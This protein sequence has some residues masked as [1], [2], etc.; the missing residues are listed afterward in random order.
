MSSIGTRPAATTGS[1]RDQI[2]HAA[3]RLFAQRGVDGVTVRE[4]VSASGQRNHGSLTYYF[5]TKDA[6]VRELV[7]DGAAVIDRRRNAELDRLE[8]QER[9]PGIRDIVEALTYPSFDIAR[10]MGGEEDNYIRFITLLSLTHRDV[11]IEAL[12]NRL[13]SGYQRCLTHLRRLMIGQPERVKNRRMIFMEAYLDSVVSLRERAL[14]GPVDR[15][16]MWQDREA[17]DDLVE[18][19]VALLLAPAPR[20]EREGKTE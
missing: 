15:P 3:L 10:E 2:K 12:E 7:A 19:I 14:S 8:A 9:P 16:H 13:N 4:I 18:T 17:V 11:F 20:P 5:G 6:L 1:A